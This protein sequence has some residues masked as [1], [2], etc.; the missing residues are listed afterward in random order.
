MP[1]IQTNTTQ[2]PAAPTLY[3]YITRSKENQWYLKAGLL[4]SLLLWIVFKCFYTQPNIIFDSY[5][6]VRPAYHHENV[7]AWPIGYSKF[8]V[9]AGLI[10]HSANFLLTVQYLLLQ[11]SFAFFFFTFRYFFPLGKTASH[12]LFFF[13][14]LNP[15]Y[16]YSSNLILSDTL[17]TTLSLLWLCQLL[18]IIFR[19]APYMIVTQALLLLLAFTVRYNALYYPL[20]AALTFLFAKRKSWFAITGIALQTVLVLWFV[21]YTE[22]EMKKIYNVADFSPFGGWKLASNALYMYEHVY[23]QKSYAVP[24]IYHKIDVITREYFDAPHQQINLMVNDPT[25]GSYYMYMAP[26]P[27]IKYMHHRFGQDTYPMDFSHFP[28]VGA[29]LKAYGNFLIHRYPKAYF[30]WFVWPNINRYFYPPQEVLVDNAN[31][32]VLREGDFGEPVKKWFH[33]SSI[34]TPRWLIQIRT[35]I[36]TPYPYLSSF[37]HFAFLLSALFFLLF[38][39]L[40]TITPA[41]RIALALVGILWLV[42]FGFNV[43][44]AGI[45]LR[46]Q[47]FILC[48]EAAATLYCI[49]RLYQHE[50]QQQL[51]TSQKGHTQPLLVS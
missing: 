25:W 11:A 32:F 17:F 28:W 24:D 37:I 29:H 30:T 22:K 8:I 15:I 48:I 1:T 35:A 2:P 49:D 19:P 12:I 46:Y 23:K 9:L 34:H 39:M 27:L 16:I 43:L 3:R 33:L 36:F 31:P 14:L 26:S 10:S 50:K 5:H 13:L 38:R 41:Q 4:I 44:A 20:I 42:D 6:Y 21:N 18:W 45:V 40:K 51:T 47:L 7:N